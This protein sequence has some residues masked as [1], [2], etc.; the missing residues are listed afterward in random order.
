MCVN[1]NL[2]SRELLSCVR[3]LVKNLSTS[4]KFAAVGVQWTNLEQNSFLCISSQC[5]DTQAILKLRAM[6]SSL[7]L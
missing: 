1:F 3:I 6:S 7:S 4:M 5:F 2:G